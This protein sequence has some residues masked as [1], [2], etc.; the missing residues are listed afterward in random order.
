MY[1]VCYN[2]I[3]IGGFFL[4]QNKTWLRANTCITV[5]VAQS[6]WSRINILCSSSLQLHCNVFMHR[7]C[8]IFLKTACP[9]AWARLR[10][11][12]HVSV[13]V[14]KRNF[15]YPFLKWSASTREQENGV[16]EK[17]H[18]EDR[19]RKVP[20]SVTV[21][22]V[23]GRPIRKKKV[24][25]SKISGYV[26]RGL[27]SHVN[28][29]RWNNSWK[30]SYNLDTCRAGKCIFLRKQRGMGVPMQMNFCMCESL[31]IQIIVYN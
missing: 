23:D 29:V 10:P 26:G 24:A 31:G 6:R 9:I 28:T 17:F 8:N 11:C 3:F 15:F 22:V 18:F 30:I 4:R 13:F 5:L 12:P 2:S 14:W 7:R 19:L 25:F 27:K 20:F 1:T 16:F 21:Y